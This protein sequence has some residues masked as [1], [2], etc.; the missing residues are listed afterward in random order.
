MKQSHTPEGYSRKMPGYK[1]HKEQVWGRLNRIEGQIRGVQK[2]VDA[3][4]F[5]IVVVAMQAT[6]HR[7]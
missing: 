6:T 3:P 5:G 7:E 1:S 4:A 2:M